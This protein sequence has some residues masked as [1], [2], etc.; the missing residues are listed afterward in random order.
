MVTEQVHVLMVTLPFHGHIN[1]MLRFAKR[2]ASKGV[3]VTFATPEVARYKQLLNTTQTDD[4]CPE[5]HLEFF[6]DGLSLE[7]N[8]VKHVDLMFASLTLEEVK[9]LPTL[10]LP[11]SPH[12]YRKLIADSIH[13]M[14]KVKWVLG[15][16]FYELE[17]DVVQSMSF[18][19]PVL[20]VG[21]LISSVAAEVNT[22][23]ARDSCLE[24]LDEKPSSS[25]VYIAFGSVIVLTQKQMENIAMALKNINRS[26]LWIMKPSEREYLEKKNDELP[27]LEKGLVVSWCDQEKV[28]RHQA[29]S[30]FLSH[31]GWNSTLEAV[32]AGV[33]V[34]AFPEWIDQPTNAKLLVDVFK[35]G[36]RMRPEEDG[37]VTKGEV[38][39][40]IFEITDG[41]RASEMKK[42]AMDLREAA[43]KAVADG[44]S[45]DRNVDHFICEIINQSGN[46]L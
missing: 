22:C 26:F 31:C 34:I 23:N 24:W 40:C 38:E 6:S 17:A 3:L 32:V 14:E 20:P 36:V 21:P 5:I 29:V 30:C 33:P 37:I 9:D 1:P 13:S 43:K 8:R 44:G 25:V 18:F 15:S 7:L 42:R 27:F 46:T 41:P 12:H 2:L 4:E 45:S 28:L 11:S 16:S 35:M 10:I 39:R 19:K